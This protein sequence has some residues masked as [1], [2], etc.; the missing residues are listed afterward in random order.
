[1]WT[2]FQYHYSLKGLV[3]QPVNCNPGPSSTG[4]DEAQKPLPGAQPDQSSHQ[5]DVQGAT[6]PERSVSLFL[7]LLRV[8]S[9]IFLVMKPKHSSKAPKAL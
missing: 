3:L 4:T 1:M 5:R 8:L 2:K 7:P 6:V 9:S